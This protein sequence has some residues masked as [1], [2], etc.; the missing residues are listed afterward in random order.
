MTTQHLRKYFLRANFK[1]CLLRQT[2]IY[3][4]ETRAMKPELYI[5]MKPELWGITTK[6][7]PQ[8]QTRIRELF[9]NKIKTPKRYALSCR[10]Y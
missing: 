6:V 2:K 4:Y 8:R 10:Q 1:T 3:T 5:P 9:K 7:I